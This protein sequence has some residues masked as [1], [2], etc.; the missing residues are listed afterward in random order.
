MNVGVA[1]EMFESDVE[2]LLVLLL[3]FVGGVRYDVRS[4]Q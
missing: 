4:R 1:I 2:C 3:K